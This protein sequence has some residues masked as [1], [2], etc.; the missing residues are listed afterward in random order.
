MYATQAAATCTWHAPPWP[1]PASR[2]LVLRVRCLPPPAGLRKAPTEPVA[3]RCRRAEMA[4]RSSRIASWAARLGP[5]PPQQQ[6]RSARSL[7]RRRRLMS[8]AAAAHQPLAGVRVLDLTRVLAGPTATQ[9][10]GDL[11]ADVR[12]AKPP[13]CCRQVLLLPPAARAHCTLKRAPL[14]AHAAGLCCRSSRL[15]IRRVGTTPG[16]GARRSRRMVR[17]RTSSQSTATSAQSRSTSQTRCRALRTSAAFAL[18]PLP[19]MTACPTAN[20]DAAHRVLMLST[21]CTWCC[22][23]CRVCPLALRLHVSA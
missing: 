5:I 12:A 11:G 2:R 8:T 16:P 20:A 19:R 3:H 1:V 6:Q 4:G 14:T 15:S 22:V 13:R 21:R 18:R 7:R 10:L 9:T 17:R 23:R